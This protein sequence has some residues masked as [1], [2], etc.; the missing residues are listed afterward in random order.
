[1]TFFASWRNLLTILTKNK[2]CFFS[3]QLKLMLFYRSGSYST[4]SQYFIYGVDAFI[5]DVGGYLVCSS[6]GGGRRNLYRRCGLLLL[7]APELLHTYI[8]FDNLQLARRL[9]VTLLHISTYPSRGH[10]QI[11]DFS[12]NPSSSIYWGLGILTG[13]L[14]LSAYKP[15]RCFQTKG[16]F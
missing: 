7:L 3:D 15:G 9:L 14:H 13:R 8:R 6:G 12:I 4:E 2:S 1:M 16:Y 10:H 11:K 5:A